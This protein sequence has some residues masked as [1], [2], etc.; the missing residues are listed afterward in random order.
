[1][2]E[3]IIPDGVELKDTEGRVINEMRL[4]L[5][6][7]MEQRFEEEREKERP[8][9]ESVKSWGHVAE[10][11]TIGDIQV[12]EVKRK[13]ETWYMPFV[14]GQRCT[15]SAYTLDL[16]IVIALSQKYDGYNTRANRYIARMIGMPDKEGESHGG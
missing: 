5:M 7:G 3:R 12:A 9:E 13:G 16:A 15:E 6:L 14:G 10:V 8:V 4:R 11:H 2:T 1:M